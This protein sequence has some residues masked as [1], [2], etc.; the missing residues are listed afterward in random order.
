MRSIASID[1]IVIAN[2]KMRLIKADK[3]PSG[4]EYRP[5]S[6]EPEGMSASGTKPP[7]DAACATDDKIST[8]SIIAASN[9]PIRMTLFRVV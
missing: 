2:E 7:S 4:P 3:S 6:L 5:E 1:P 8:D 9:M